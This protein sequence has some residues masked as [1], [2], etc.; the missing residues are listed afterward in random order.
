MLIHRQDARA[1]LGLHNLHYIQQHD[2]LREL[3]IHQCDEKPVEERMRIYINIKGND[4]P[5][6]WFEQRLQPLQA[7]VLSIVTGLLSIPS[8]PFR[9]NIEMSSVDLLH[10]VSAI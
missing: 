4:F 9:S 5:R 8:P 10:L 3:V 6:W 1:V 7:E 2:M